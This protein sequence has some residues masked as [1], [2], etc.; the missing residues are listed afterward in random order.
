M[1]DFIPGLSKCDGVPC[2]MGIVLN[3]TTWEEAKQS[4]G[5]KPGFNTTPQFKGW[6]VTEGPVEYVN[7]FFDQDIIFEVDLFPRD[8]SLMAYGLLIDPGIPCAVYAITDTT[9]QSLLVLAYP[10]R[11]GWVIADHWRITPSSQIIEI[12]LGPA[13]PEA[14]NVETTDVR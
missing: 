13:A 12:E 5:N 8:G 3:K 10:D 14:A 6:I 2:Y 7:T 11:D 9:Y 1:P 4:V